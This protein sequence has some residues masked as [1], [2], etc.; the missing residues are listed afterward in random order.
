LQQNPYGGGVW[1]KNA[2]RGLQGI[3][4]IA[5]IAVI[6]RD[7]KS[8]TSPRINTDDTDQIQGF[9]YFMKAG[10]FLLHFPRTNA[11]GEVL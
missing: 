9:G 5:D 2:G 6:A 3:A 10:K 8:K 1:L 7:R 11:I 4:G